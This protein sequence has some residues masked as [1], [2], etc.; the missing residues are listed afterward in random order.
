MRYVFLGQG[1]ILSIAFNRSSLR[2]TSV[3]N[4]RR[5]DKRRAEA[6]RLILCHFRG[7]L[8]ERARFPISYDVSLN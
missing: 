3:A 2:A 7:L 6:R 4:R 1:P 8:P 5:K